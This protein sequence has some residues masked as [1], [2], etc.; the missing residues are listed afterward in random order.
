[1]AKI[2]WSP[3]TKDVEGVAT[4][5]RFTSSAISST[6][7]A[8]LPRPRP[9][10]DFEAGAPA[11][12]WATPVSDPNT[13]ALAKAAMARFDITFH[14]MGHLETGLCSFFGQSQTLNTESAILDQS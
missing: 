4:T 6:S 1:M 3:E 7:G 14:F 12:S 11:F 9:K 8:R 5:A 10:A 13:I 2:V